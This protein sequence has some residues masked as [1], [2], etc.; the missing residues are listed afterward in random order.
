[1]INIKNLNT[2]NAVFKI[3]NFIKNK[4]E[5]TLKLFNRML[6]IIILS[7]V[8]GYSNISL[9][10]DLNGFNRLIFKF[11]DLMSTDKE[12]QNTDSVKL[13][14][15]STL[16]NSLILL[17]V[18]GSVFEININEEKKGYK[19]IE[20][21]GSN[22]IIEKNNKQYTLKL[23]NSPILIN[24]VTAVFKSNLKPKDNFNNFENDAIILNENESYQNAL[25]EKIS[26][27]E[28]SNFE[29]KIVDELVKDIGRSTTGRLGVKIPSFIVG[30]NVSQFGL[31]ENDVILTI[32]N[33]P[34]GNVNDIY[35][36]YK[37]ETIETYFVEI[38]RMDKLIMLEW[39]K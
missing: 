24:V 33:I 19:L 25:I 26:K 6:Q 20:V 13:I 21:D 14:G 18:N 39:F 11:N 32:N 17:E 12:K 1:M 3:V 8:S 9:A 7:I 37:D 31:R 4:K 27:V 29:K 36:L 10:N 15:I 30:Q 2:L 5:V 16:K 38:K 34:I 22:A 28:F 35:N 23:G